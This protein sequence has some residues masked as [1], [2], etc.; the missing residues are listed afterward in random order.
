MCTLWKSTD[1]K[2]LDGIERCGVKGDNPH[3][4]TFAIP[5]SIAREILDP[6]QYGAGHVGGHAI[7][8][9]TREYTRL[10]VRATIQ[11]L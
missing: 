5:G 4:Y 6:I 8:D 1:P 10:L 11:G 2:S 7:W 3:E 9:E